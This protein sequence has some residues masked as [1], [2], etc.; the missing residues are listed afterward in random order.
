MCARILEP[1]D[2]SQRIYSVES[3]CG[4]C[5][6]SLQRYHRKTSYCSYATS[7][8]FIYSS[9]IF[10]SL[11][12]A[13]CSLKVR[14]HSQ[15]K[16][17]EQLLIL[18]WTVLLMM[19]M[20]GTAVTCV[21]GRVHW[22]TAAKCRENEVQIVRPFIYIANSE[23]SWVFIFLYCNCVVWQEET[24]FTSPLR[25]S[26]AFI[27]RCPVVRAISCWSNCV[28]LSEVCLNCHWQK[29]NVQYYLILHWK[30]CTCAVGDCKKTYIFSTRWDILYFRNLYLLI[31]FSSEK[32]TQNLFLGIV[33]H[34]KFMAQQSK[35]ST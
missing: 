32:S 34:F 33:V 15:Q 12:R 23:Y 13:E 10:L 25:L 16:E 14:E 4:R 21:L 22:K 20:L 27:R 26:D 1:V 35:Y 17:N 30:T 6:T 7:A 5:L 19:S 11:P 9:N 8:V 18:S 3:S 31:H 24:N 2:P 28:S 29:T